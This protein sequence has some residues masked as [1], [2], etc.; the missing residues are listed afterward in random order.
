MKIKS[1]R[2]LGKS[3]VNSHSINTSYV[4]SNCQSKLNSSIETKNKHWI[5]LKRVFQNLDGKHIATILGVLDKGSEVVVK[6]QP[7]HMARNEFMFEQILRDFRGFIEFGCMVT[8]GSTI[9]RIDKLKNVKKEKLCDKK[10]DNIGIIVMPYYKN[11]SFKEFLDNYKGGKRT[12]HI[13]VLAI[14]SYY[15]AYKKLGFVHGDFYTKNIVVDEN[16]RPLIID[17]EHSSFNS[18]FKL[19]LFWRDIENFLSCIYPFVNKDLNSIIR[20][21]VVMNNAHSIEPDDK[22]IKALIDAILSLYRIVPKLRPP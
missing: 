2:Q 22:I 8:C 12:I 7:I 6:I 9:D 10:G 14:L 16:Y 20:T 15:I 18:Q 19:S 13:T 21:H 17:F 5:Q 3:N 1:I 4:L 11:G